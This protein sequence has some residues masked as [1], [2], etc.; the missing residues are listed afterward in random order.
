MMNLGVNL[1]SSGS[2]R[3]TK[4]IGV[5]LREGVAPVFDGS[6]LVNP[7]TASAAPILEAP[8]FENF[9]LTV[10]RNAAPVFDGSVLVDPGSVSTP[11]SRLAPSFESFVLTAE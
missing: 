3:V 5:V 4:D 7:G 6:V 11:A 8:S 10:T 1:S 2:C 9:V